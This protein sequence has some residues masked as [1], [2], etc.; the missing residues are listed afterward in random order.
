MSPL[1]DKIPTHC[2]K[3]PVKTVFVLET[4]RKTIRSWPSEVKKELGAVLLRLQQGETI[5]MPDVRPMP[6][7]GRGVSEIRIQDSSG[8]Y[9]TFYAIESQQ[10]IIV[11]HSFKK[12]TQKTPL[13]EILTAKARLAEFTKQIGNET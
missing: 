6:S 1:W 13:K 7:V 5:G 9:R 8:A 4:A 2:E 11:F 10:G 12:K 3:W